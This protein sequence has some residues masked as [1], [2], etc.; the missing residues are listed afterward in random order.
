MPYADDPK[1]LNN[2]TLKE[3]ALLITQCITKC[4]Q[5]LSDLEGQSAQMKEYGKVLLQLGIQQ[6]QYKPIKQAMMNTITMGLQEKMNKDTN[7]A[8]INFL[9]YTSEML[10]STNYEVQSDF[11]YAELSQSEMIIL[12]DSWS[13]LE[14]YDQTILGRQIYSKLIT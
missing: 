14:N 1:L 6:E 3:H 2:A 11:S 13:K 4:I 5:E 8:W 12:N 9:K 7:H 10:I